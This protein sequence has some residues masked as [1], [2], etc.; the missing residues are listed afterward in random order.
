MFSVSLKNIGKKFNHSWAF[1]RL[2]YEFTGEN[3]YAILGNNGSGK[4][5]LLQMISGF[6]S[7]TEGDIFYTK[8]GK[9]IP[10]D[11][12][13]NHLSM[14]SP[15]MELPEELTFAEVLRFH[16]KFKKPLVDLNLIP[17]KAQLAKE[18]DKELKH[19]S[20]GMKQRVKLSLALF[21]ASDMIL[22]DEPTSHLD[23]NGANWYNQTLA[24]YSQN[25]LLIIASNEPEEYRICGEFLKLN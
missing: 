15:F 8:D 20:S 2:D 3:N 11:E 16:A 10:P 24:E 21:F 12:V 18:A 22:L 6:L 13:F 14:A 19:Y 17:A 5:T 1:R 9:T 7:S 23:E 25:R 4:S